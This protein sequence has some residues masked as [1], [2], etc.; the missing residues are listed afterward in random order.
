MTRP[1]VRYWIHSTV[2]AVRGLRDEASLAADRRRDLESEIRRER[3]HRRE[4]N[5]DLSMMWKDTYAPKGGSYVSQ[6]W[7]WVAA[8]EKR[9][10][11]LEDER[12]QMA[13]MPMLPY[14]PAAGYGAPTML[15]SERSHQVMMPYPSSVPQLYSSPPMAAGAPYSR[16]FVEEVTPRVAAE[17]VNPE[18][19]DSRTA[20]GA[21]HKTSDA[22]A[23]RRCPQRHG[24]A[25]TD[26]PRAP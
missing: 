17:P 11:H 13:A 23:S 2:E 19:P 10:R 4:M 6:L 1:A 24:S 21:P 16:S 7:D 3:D 9:V 22:D 20:S 25:R 14:A 18:A 26:P 15:L 5:K 8:L 12:R